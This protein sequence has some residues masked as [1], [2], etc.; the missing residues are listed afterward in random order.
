MKR[1][2]VE[3][4]HDKPLMTMLSD[5]E[6][7]E[8]DRL[9]KERGISLRDLVVTSVLGSEPSSL[10]ARTIDIECR[11]NTLEHQLRGY[12]DVIRALRPDVKY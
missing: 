11:L 12:L 5:A 7:A 1:T 9:A 10:L 3:R 2:K 4:R 8:F 6:R